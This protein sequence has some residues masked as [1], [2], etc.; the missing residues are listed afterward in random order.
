MVPNL[1][2]TQDWKVVLKVVSGNSLHYSNPICSLLTYTSLAAHSIIRELP[3][4]T[5][6]KSV[7]KQILPNYC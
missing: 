1:T 4:K 2:E 7:S 5:I 6:P 3:S